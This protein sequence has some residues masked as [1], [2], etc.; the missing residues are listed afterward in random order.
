M[1]LLTLTET[2]QQEAKNLL[3]RIDNGE[4]HHPQNIV[5]EWELGPSWA[6]LEDRSGRDPFELE[7]EKMWVDPSN[8]LGVQGPPSRGRLPD[9][10]DDVKTSRLEQILR[11][12]L[13]GKYELE[14]EELPHYVKFDG[15]LYVTVDGRHRSLIFKA[16]DIDELLANVTVVR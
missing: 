2:Q 14:Y 7:S 5:S 3:Q 12:M 4:I 8:I 15:S 1:V 11:K 9:G 10:N 6:E 13:S 16:L